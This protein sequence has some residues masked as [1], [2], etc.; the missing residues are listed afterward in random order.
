MPYSMSL[1]NGSRS[2]LG[3]CGRLKYMIVQLSDRGVIQALCSG[4]AKENFVF[5]PLEWK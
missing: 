1:G 2:L 5:R 4:T 3:L